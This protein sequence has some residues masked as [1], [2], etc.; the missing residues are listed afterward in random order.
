VDSVDHEVDQEEV[1]VEEVTS[2][3]KILDHL[4]LLYHMVPF[5]IDAKINSLSNVQI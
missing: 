3:N 5:Y 4:H 2:V 1:E